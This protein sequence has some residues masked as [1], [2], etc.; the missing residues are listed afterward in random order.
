LT[1]TTATGRTVTTY[2]SVYDHP[3]NLPVETSTLEARHGRRLARV[4]NPDIP[5]HLSIFDEIGWAQ[6]LAPAT[7]T[8]RQHQWPVKRAVGTQRPSQDRPAVTVAPADEAPPPF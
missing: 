5:G 8:Q 3:D 1:W 2:P 6:A 7:P 4:I